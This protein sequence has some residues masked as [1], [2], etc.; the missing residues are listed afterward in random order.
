MKSKYKKFFFNDFKKFLFFLKKSRTDESDPSTSIFDIQTL[1]QLLL[2]Y[3]FKSKDEINSINQVLGN[4]LSSDF[5]LFFLIIQ[6]KM[7]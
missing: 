4:S 3:K 2:I 7:I 6:M 5:F 1:T